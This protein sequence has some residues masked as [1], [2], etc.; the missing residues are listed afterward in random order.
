MAI[1]VEVV[2]AAEGR[3]DQFDVLIVDDDE[4]IRDFLACVLDNV[5]LRCRSVASLEQARAMSGLDHIA[6]VILDLSLGSGDAVD[7]LDH[8]ADQDYAGGVMLISGYDIAALEPMQH[9]GTT[10]GLTMWPYQTKPV[11]P[12]ALRLAVQTLIA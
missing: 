5:G 4:A 11:R 3:S 8:L 9:L 1:G 7:V 10:I 2:P 12:Q 6:L